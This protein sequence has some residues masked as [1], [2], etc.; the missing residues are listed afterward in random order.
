MDGGCISCLRH[1]LHA[2]GQRFSTLMS[3]MSGKLPFGTAPRG[4]RSAAMA[5]DKL[6]DEATEVTT[7]DGEVILDGP[8][9]VDVKITPESAQETAENLVEGRGHGRRSAAS[10]RPTPQAAV[11]GSEQHNRRSDA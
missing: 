10:Q 8:D 4:G 11:I 6:Y 3:A 2:V 9:A 1:R 7:K 5:R